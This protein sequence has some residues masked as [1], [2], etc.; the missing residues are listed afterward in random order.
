VGSLGACPARQPVLRPPA[1]FPVTLL[2]R[3]SLGVVFDV[4]FDCANDSTR[5]T[6]KNPGHGDYQVNARLNL[7]ALGHIDANPDGDVCPRSVPP[8]GVVEP[9]ASGTILD[10]GCGALKADRTFG[11]PIL[12]DVI[13]NP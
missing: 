5:T 2:S 12:I 1:R 10:K 8:P 11:A 6:P 7:S 13:K 9:N 3:R 4:T